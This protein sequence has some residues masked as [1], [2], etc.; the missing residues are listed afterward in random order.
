MIHIQ[1]ISLS[2]GEQKVFDSIN[3]IINADDR[4]GLVGRNGAGKSTLLKAIAHLQPLDSGT[5]A[6]IGSK[7]IAYMPQDIVLSSKKNIVEEALT[8]HEHIEPEDLPTLTAEAKKMLMGIGFS[9]ER[10]QQNVDQL[11]TGWKM[12]LI[13]AKLLLSKADFYLFDEPTNHLDIFAQEWFLRFLKRASFGFLLV[14]HERAFLNKACNQILELNFGKA[15]RYNGNYDLYLKQKK[16]SQERHRAAYMHQQ[17]DIA[18]KKSTIERFRAK[19]SKARMA[20]SMQKQLDKMELIEE[21]DREEKTISITFAPTTRPER[22]VLR[23]QNL[24]KKFQEST[25]FSHVN[26]RV[27]RNNKIALVAANGVGKTTLLKTITGIH[28]ADTGI[29]QFGNEVNYSFFKQ[30][31]NSSLDPKA[32]IWDEVSYSTRKR[33]DLEIR[34]FLGTFLFPGDDV[35]KQ[36]EVLSGG[37]KNRVSMVKT[38][39]K[40]SNFLILDEP[41]NHLDMQ[42]KEVLL[43]ALKNYPGTIFFVSHDQDFVNR[44]AT[45]I[46]ELTPQGTTTYPGNYD[47]YIAQKHLTLEVQNTEKKSI[48]KFTQTQEIDKQKR[49]EHFEKEKAL[50]RLESK[51]EKLEQKI[52]TETEKLS[53]YEYGT[54][55]FSSSYDAIAV[56]QKQHATLSDEWEHAV[57][58]LD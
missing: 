17:K 28:E 12:R 49:K 15:T 11:S 47:D 39:L 51:I 18:Q 13:L 20:K 2:F 14:C 10:L 35:H 22:T 7:K 57:E 1:Q 46:I 56:M 30:D 23:V 53:I 9:L 54:P 27:E 31:Q 29:I 25:V 37:E 48:T 55:E 24:S 6:L 33:T 52:K 45:H 32:T 42:S 21:P 16:E 26:F 3:S 4:I 8:A 41:T 58:E 43:Q 44:L 38:L 5:I 40:G 50:K 19:S 36:I 34:S